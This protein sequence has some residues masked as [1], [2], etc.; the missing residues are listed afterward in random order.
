[1]VILKWFLLHSEMFDA[2]KTSVLHAIT[3]SGH[4]H[5]RPT[6]CTGTI[7]HVASVLLRHTYLLIQGLAYLVCKG[8]KPPGTCPHRAS[9]C[10][11]ALTQYP[12][13]GCWCIMNGSV[14]A[15]AELQ[16]EGHS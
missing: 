14:G 6:Q 12:S 1:M 16:R 15:V 2:E 5:S 11:Y 3:K 9:T 4:V 7:G 8:V 13:S 10:H